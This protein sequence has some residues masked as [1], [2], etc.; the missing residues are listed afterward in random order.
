MKRPSSPVSLPAN[1][2]FVVQ[3]AA[4]AAPEQGAISG[5]VEHVVSMEA[6]HFHSVEELMSFM[7]RILNTLAVDDDTND[8]E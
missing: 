8:S 3:V 1:R 7:I 2:A 5:R 6:T 4:E